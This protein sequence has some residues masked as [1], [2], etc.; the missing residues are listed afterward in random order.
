[1]R[2]QPDDIDLRMQIASLTAKYV[3][4]KDAI[5]WYEILLK[6]APHH[7]PARAALAELYRQTGDTEKANQQTDDEMRGAKVR[8]SS[9]L[10][11]AH[12]SGPDSKASPE[13][14]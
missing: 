12:N 8:N 2:K 3:S 11:Q 6:V 13:V 4:R 7:A 1:L 9:D 5:R 10:G 14:R